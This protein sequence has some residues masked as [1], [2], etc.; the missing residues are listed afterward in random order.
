MNLTNENF[1]AIMTGILMF[2]LIVAIALLF[3][4]FVDKNDDNPNF[5]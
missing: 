1:N 2:A 3:N 4:V 5:S